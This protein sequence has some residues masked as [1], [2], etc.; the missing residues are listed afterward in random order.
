MKKSLVT[1]T[2]IVAVSA[3]LAACGSEESGEEQ[4][5]GSGEEETAEQ[6]EQSSEEEEA[7]NEEE[8]SGEI[9]APEDVAVQGLADHYHTGD[10]V[11]LTAELEEDI[12]SDHWH[13]YEKAA[14]SEEWEPVSGQESAEYNGEAEND[15]QE[16]KAV[17]YDEDHKPHA[18]SAPVEIA[19]DDHEGEEGHSH[20]LS[21]D[22]QRIYDGYFE[23]EE[24]EERE[25]TDWEGDW[26]SVYPYLQDG[27]LDEVFEYKAEEDDEMTAEE[28][29]EYYE[30]GYETNVERIIFDGSQA[31]FFENG[32]EYTGN[33]V[34]D[35]YEILEYEAGNR[36]VRYVYKLDGE[37]EGMPQYIQ[38][39]DH[40]VTPTDA[41]HFHLY[42]GD[43][44]EALLDEVE[45]WPTYYPSNMDE[46]DIVHEM[47]AH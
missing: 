24:V 15:G 41:H 37:A 16:V 33:Y 20:E 38:F 22:E 13:W 32:E 3:M 23:D 9:D 25:L 11:T 6:E 18:Q 31:A 5:Q 10:E 46:D 47:T 27:D 30:E 40:D 42:W 7:K 19:I 36:G 14:D 12:D 21:E 28:Y 29:K 34:S 17:I 39:S 1:L 35:G 4:N 44:R 45:N 2:S 26:Q 43:D 8:H